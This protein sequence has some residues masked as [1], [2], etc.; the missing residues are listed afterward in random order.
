MPE[1]KNE[2]V[3]RNSLKALLKDSLDWIESE[4]KTLLQDSPFS[5]ASNTEIKLFAALRG[6]SR[7]ISELSRYLGVSRQAVHHTVHKLVE[8]KVVELQHS[9]SNKRDKLVVISD[10]GREVQAMTA[11]HF[12][13]IESRMANNIGRD[14]V[15]LLRELLLENRTKIEAHT[16]GF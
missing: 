9:E 13:T 11:K 10:R 6:Q 16:K 12:K 7:S 3:L 4:Q 15:E 1:R 2:N 14:K 8:K 5:S